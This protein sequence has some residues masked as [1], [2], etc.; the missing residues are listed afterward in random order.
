MSRRL[1]IA[2]AIAACVAWVSCSRPLRSESYVPNDGSGSYV[3]DL[4][5]SDSL[6]TYN[7]Y[8]FASLRHGETIAGFPV[9][10]YLTAPGGQ[11]YAESVF[12]DLGGGA[13]KPYR[14]GLTPVEY[15][16]WRLEL[17]TDAAALYGLGLICEREYGD[18]TR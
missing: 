14:R 13:T 6:C 18:G 8:F 7:L 16:V 3:F 10:V 1:I 15:G 4:D 5:M 12:Y 2:L 11:E 17:K 9:R